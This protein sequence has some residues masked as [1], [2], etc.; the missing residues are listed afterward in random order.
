[1]EQVLALVCGW[2]L[3]ILHSVFVVRPI[4]KIDHPILYVMLGVNYALVI[5]LIF[6]YVQITFLDPVDSFIL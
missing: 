3:V 2:G 5:G 6:T 1:M 4:I